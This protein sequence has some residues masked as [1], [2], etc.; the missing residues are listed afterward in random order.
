MLNAVLR[1]MMPS[2]IAQILTTSLDLSGQ[3]LSL[4]MMKSHIFTLYWYEN[5]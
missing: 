2:L 3:S 5:E 4:K 1:V